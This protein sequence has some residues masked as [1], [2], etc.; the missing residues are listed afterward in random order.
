[1]GEEER[2]NLNTGEAIKVNILNS[3]RGYPLSG[4]L[5]KERLCSSSLSAQR[6]LTPVPLLS[7]PPVLPSSVCGESLLLIPATASVCT[8]A[9]EAK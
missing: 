5:N 1:M 3:N 6:S 9:K 2:E 7:F 8:A 4:S